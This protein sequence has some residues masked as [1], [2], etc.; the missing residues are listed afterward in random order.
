MKI[1]RNISRAKWTPSRPLN[2][3]EIPAD[4]LADLKTK[5]NCLSYWRCGDGEPENI[6]N[7]ALALASARER[8]AKL[9]MV[10]LDE[11]DVQSLDVEITQT[12]GKT[13]AAKHRDQHV[14]V[15]RLDLRR[16]CNLAELTAEAIGKKRF[17]RFGP[18]E[19]KT[20]L[21]KAVNSGEI[22]LD[23]LDEKLKA[24]VHKELQR[25]R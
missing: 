7:I 13:P 8:L 3:D 18:K 19:I 15:G 2:D 12:E 6:K 5:D 25:G 20:M 4:G 16:I 17:K 23:E 24:D 11:S 9:D 14:D 1:A 21:A 22:S 10:W